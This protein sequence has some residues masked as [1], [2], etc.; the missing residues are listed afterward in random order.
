MDSSPSLSF[1]AGST[2]IGIT[3]SV[4]QL[5]QTEMTTRS[6]KRGGGVGM[7]KLG[8]LGLHDLPGWHSVTVI[9]TLSDMNAQDLI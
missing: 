9:S 3:T 4:G 2:A 1:Y 6:R 7:S 8:F 5:S